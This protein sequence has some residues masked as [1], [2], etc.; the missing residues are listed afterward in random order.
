MTLIVSLELRGESHGSYP[1]IEGGGVG[2]VDL[3]DVAD[4]THASLKTN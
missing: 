4:M 2:E 1:C 3:G